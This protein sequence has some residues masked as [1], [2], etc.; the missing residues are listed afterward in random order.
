MKKSNKTSNTLKSISQTILLI[1]TFFLTLCSAD[2]SGWTLLNRC[3]FNHYFTQGLE[4]MP[5]GKSLLVSTG[6]YKNSKVV[7]LDFDINE[8]S[9]KEIFEYKLED[10]YFGEGA[11]LLE[12]NGIEYVHVL[13]WK[14]RKVIIFKAVRNDE[15]VVDKLEFI[16]EK[17]I[18]K[19][20]K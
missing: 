19:E 20:I 1:S 9:F 4:I 17:D 16:E 3:K 6:W 13:T 18:P 12:F 15:D 5:G 8:C 7:L 2:E 14:E 10:K 11:T